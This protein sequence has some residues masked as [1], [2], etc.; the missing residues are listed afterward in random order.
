MSIRTKV[1]YTARP[2]AGNSRCHSVP[3]EAVQLALNDP[4]ALLSSLQLRLCL[5]KITVIDHN[6]IVARY[7]QTLMHT[8]PDNDLICSEEQFPNFPARL[9]DHARLVVE[10]LVI[11]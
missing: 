4:Q 2:L 10:L 11:D 8:T 3:I 1:I 7:P 6:K 9:S 5:V